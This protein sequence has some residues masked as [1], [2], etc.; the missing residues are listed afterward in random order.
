MKKYLTGIVLLYASQYAVADTTLVFKDI[1][2]KQGDY[3]L[4]YQIKDGKLRLTESSSD[5]IN[6]F[7]STKQEFVSYNPKTQQSEKLNPAIIDKRAKL[8][9]K[10]RLKKLTEVEKELNKKLESM[11]ETEREV[12]TD[13]VNQLKYPEYYGAHTH[14]KIT[15]NDKSKL[16]N[17][18]ECQVY[19]ISRKD[20]RVRELCIASPEAIPG[21]DHTTLQSFYA[22]EYKLTSQLMLAM[23]KS[24]FT[25][26]DHKELGINGV[27]IENIEYSKNKVMQHLLLKSISKD[28]LGKEIFSLPLKNSKQG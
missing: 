16:I 2:K 5:R 28:T 6:I 3:S 15:A 18:I 21:N 26:V 1:N 23:G 17:D 20:E 11:N 10:Q 24:D 13:L 22:F 14:L 25:V 19:T 9:N 12:G 7:D 27:V 8:L 4:N